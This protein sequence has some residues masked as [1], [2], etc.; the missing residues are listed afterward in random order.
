[1]AESPC[2]ILIVSHNGLVG[3]LLSSKA[4][5]FGGAPGTRVPKALL[6]TGEIAARFAAGAFGDVCTLAWKITGSHPVLF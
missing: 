3:R 4:T 5:P 1:M 2:T 6:P